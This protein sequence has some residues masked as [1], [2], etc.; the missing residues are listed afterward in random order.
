MVLLCSLKIDAQFQGL[1]VIV[2]KS[3]RILTVLW[4]VWVRG[5]RHIPQVWKQTHDL[6]QQLPFQV[7]K[8]HGRFLDGHAWLALGHLHASNQ[9]ILSLHGRCNWSRQQLRRRLFV[10]ITNYAVVVRQLNCTATEQA[11]KHCLWASKP[12]RNAWLR[13]LKALRR[14]NSV[15]CLAFTRALNFFTSSPSPLWDT[16]IFV[17]SL[18]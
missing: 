18:R 13:M 17:G 10:R 14:L 4:M 11:S 1:E 12:W 9:A 2:R 8:S 15:S 7:K 5:R 3:R 16:D 6:S